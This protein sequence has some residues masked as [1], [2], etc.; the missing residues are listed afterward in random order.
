MGKLGCLL[1]NELQNHPQVQVFYGMDRDFIKKKRKGVENF[2]D[3][4]AV[5]VTPIFS[6]D[7]IKANLENKYSC[8]ILSLEDIVCRL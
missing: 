3:V 1:C 8:S 7:S 2:S 4:D 5:I 6:F